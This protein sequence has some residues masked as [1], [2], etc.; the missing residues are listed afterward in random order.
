MPMKPMPAR[1]MRIISYLPGPALLVGH[2]RFQALFSRSSRPGRTDCASFGPLSE[3]E[4]DS[5]PAGAQ[6]CM[7]AEM[8]G[9]LAWR[10]NGMCRGREFVATG[11][12]NGVASSHANAT[13]DAR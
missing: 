10:D 3:A 1:P 5:A 11:E 8:D 7:T 4:W 13:L 12:N 2:D 9:A 6:E